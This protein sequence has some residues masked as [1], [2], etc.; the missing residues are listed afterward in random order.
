MKLTPSKNV[1]IE[2]FGCQM[3][4]NDTERLLGFLAPL[5]FKRTESAAEAAL[6]LLNTCSVRDKAEQKVYSAAGRFKGLK[7]NGSGPVIAICGCVAQQEGEALLKRLPYLD[8]VFGPGSIHRIGELLEAVTGGKKRVA[9]TEQASE[10]ARDEFP[11]YAPAEGLKKAYVS[12]MRGCDNFCSYC[13]V[14]YTRGREQSRESA[15]IIREVSSLAASGVMEVTLLGQNV[16]SYGIKSGGG[17]NFADLLRNVCAVAGIER[18]RYVTSHPKDISEELIRLFADE[19]KLSRHIHLPLQSGSDAVLKRMKRGYT[20]GEYFDKISLL[21]SLYPDISITTDIIVGFPG[22]SSED[23]RETMA[24]LERV[25]FDGIFSFKYSP[26]P[27]T[28]AATFTDTVGEEE[29]SRRLASLQELQREITDEKNR[30][31]IGTIADVFIEGPS[32][33][34]SNELTGRTSCNRVVNLKAPLELEG[35]IVDVLITDA[36]ANSL[37]GRYNDGSLTCL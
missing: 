29:K 32:K 19:P 28:L 37:R 23:F 31:L 21:Q 35:S 33:N 22:E 13:I 20:S 6:I 36:Y 18:V 2:T 27:E 3:N 17:T 30:R 8:L 1:Y 25:R 11:S 10:I 24:A 9:L 5:G 16:N 15:D 7:E 12:I 14:P 34:N 4:D 26:R